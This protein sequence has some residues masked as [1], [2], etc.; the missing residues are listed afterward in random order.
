M[1]VKSFQGTKFTKVKNAADKI[2]KLVHFCCFP[3]RLLNKSSIGDVIKTY[4]E[5]DALDL[6]NNKNTLAHVYVYII[7]TS[8]KDFCSL[9]DTLLYSNTNINFVPRNKKL[10]RLGLL[11]GVWQEQFNSTKLII[12]ESHS[13]F[14]LIRAL[15][16][17]VYSGI[18]IS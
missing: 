8:V 5:L 3:N 1:E 11:V 15:I 14:K 7:Y 12:T 9:L 2:G 6:I 16:K 10:I 13:E 18:N 17:E 4:V